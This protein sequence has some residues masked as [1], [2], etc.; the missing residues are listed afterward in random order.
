MP[1]TYILCYSKEKLQQQH[2]I[3]ERLGQ[4]QPVRAF[5]KD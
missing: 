3:K 5:S 2:Y 4:S 1:I